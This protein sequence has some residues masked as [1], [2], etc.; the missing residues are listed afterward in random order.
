M[1]VKTLNMQFLAGIEESRWTEFFVP[2]VSLKGRWW[3]VYKL[4]GGKRTEDLQR[5]IVQTE[6]DTECTL[7]LSWGDMYSLFTD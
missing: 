4:P 1:S 2:D 5:R 3:S 7:T 6:T